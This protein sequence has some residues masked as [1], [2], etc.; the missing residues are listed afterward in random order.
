M[1]FDARRVASRE[2]PEG[3]R[4]YLRPFR[5]AHLFFLSRQLRPQALVERPVSTTI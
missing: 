4:D 1:Q 3:D 5:A 2:S